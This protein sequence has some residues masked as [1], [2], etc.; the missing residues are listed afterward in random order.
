MTRA[1]QTAFAGLL[2]S[3]LTERR[4]EGDAAAQ[5]PACRAPDRALVSLGC[6]PPGT[7]GPEL[8]VPF[9]RAPTQALAFMKV[10][11]GEYARKETPTY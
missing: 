11:G 7:K 4:P 5:L 3:V 1:E 10:L 9:F 8:A 2:K 6:A